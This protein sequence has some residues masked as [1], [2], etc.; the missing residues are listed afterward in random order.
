MQKRL[1]VL[2]EIL[3]KP[4]SGLILLF[5]A[6]GGNAPTIISFIGFVLRKDTST[7][8]NYIMNSSFYRFFVSNWIWFTIIV[9]LV[10]AWEDIFRKA[11][12][13][14]GERIIADKIFLLPG[15]EALSKDSLYA[16]VLVQNN[17]NYDL[18]DCKAILKTI[19]VK[20]DGKWVNK[21]NELNP[22]YSPLTFPRFKPEEEKVVSSLGNERINIVKYVPN[23]FAFIFENGW[24]PKVQPFTDFEYH[25][26]VK[27]SGKMK[28]KLIEDKELHGFIRYSSQLRSFTYKLDGTINWMTDEFTEGKEVEEVYVDVTKLYIEPGELEENEV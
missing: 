20:I 8:E 7:I 5:L 21:T 17:E 22:N 6:I 19:K 4:V 23:T 1:Q 11:R 16:Y 10:M 14:L 25:I 26:E 2:K 3:L 28:D 13:Y 15:E 27:L 18:E 12:G 24:E 9:F